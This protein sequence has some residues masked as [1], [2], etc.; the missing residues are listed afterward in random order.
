MFAVSL[1]GMAMILTLGFIHGNLFHS[2]EIT[3]GVFGA[4]V[5]PILMLSGVLF[6]LHIL[7]NII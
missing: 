5:A 7:P 3:S 4:L 2:V 6:P 1:L